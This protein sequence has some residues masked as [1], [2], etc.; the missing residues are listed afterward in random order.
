MKLAMSLPKV[1]QDFW[2]YRKRGKTGNFEIGTGDKKET[3]K[4]WTLEDSEFYKHRLTFVN[5]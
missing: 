5:C 1:S 3:K 4:L 2:T